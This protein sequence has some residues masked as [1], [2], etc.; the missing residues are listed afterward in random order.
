MNK[1]DLAR[2]LNETKKMPD[3]KTTNRLLDRTVFAGEN[4]R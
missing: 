1:D 2:L 3:K 4:K